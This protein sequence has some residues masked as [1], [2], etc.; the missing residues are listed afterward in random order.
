LH[1][2]PSRQLVV[3]D[4]TADCDPQVRVL[5]RP[6]GGGICNR[7]RNSVN[8]FVGAIGWVEKDGG[9][10][11]AVVVIEASRPVAVNDADALQSV[12]KLVKP[13]PCRSTG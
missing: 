2:I 1:G 4:V 3:A 6:C 10:V 12:S 13:M 5:T 7:L 9:V 11:S 8:E